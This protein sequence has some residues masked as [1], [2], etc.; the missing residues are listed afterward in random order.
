M[1]R[2]IATIELHALHDR[3]LGLGRLAFF[4]RDDAV[5][6]TDLLHGLGELLADLGIVVGGDGRDFGDF[7]FVLV[8]DFFSQA[9]ELLDE[10]I[11]SL[12]NAAGQGHRVGAGSNVLEPFAIDGLGERGRGAVAGHVAGLAGC[13]LDELSAHVL[14]GIFEL[15]FLRHGDAVLGDVRTAPALIEHGVAAAGAEGRAN[16][17]RQLA[18]SGQKLVPGLIAV[19]QLFC[20]H[21]GISFHFCRSNCPR[22]RSR[23]ERFQESVALSRVP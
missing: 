19:R 23:K 12:L 8:V 3:D 7:L 16:G 11:D 15:D 14:V 5:G 6:S 4:D 2:E 9:M 20:R 22:P 1:R 13:F 17:P 10:Q 18:H 21:P